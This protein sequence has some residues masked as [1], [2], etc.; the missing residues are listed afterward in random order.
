ME[1]A[2]FEKKKTGIRKEVWEGDEGPEERIN[3]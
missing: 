3:K 1:M 2:I